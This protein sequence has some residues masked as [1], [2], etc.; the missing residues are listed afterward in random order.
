[1]HD[2]A[3][4][5]ELIELLASKTELKQ[6][7]IH[8]LIDD[9]WAVISK[10]LIEGDTIELRGFGTFEIKRRKGRI[11][12]RNPKTGEKVSVEDHGVVFFRP[13]RELKRKARKVIN[14]KPSS[15]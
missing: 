14:E 15:V 2:K 4:K 11:N 3:T 13:G 10:S 6:K 8:K 5:A 1:M 7:D 12:A 9:L